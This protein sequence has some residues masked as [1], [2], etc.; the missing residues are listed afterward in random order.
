VKA[1]YCAIAEPAPARAAR[2]GR[3]ADG[4]IAGIAAGVN[5]VWRLAPRAGLV[6]ED[7]RDRA[8]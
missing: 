7:E 3:R 8:H 4:S 5:Q 2:Q 6:A 1:V